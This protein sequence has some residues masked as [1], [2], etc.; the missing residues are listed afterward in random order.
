MSAILLKQQYALLKGSRQAL[1]TYCETIA[2]DDLIRGIEGFGFSSITNLLCHVANSYT[3][4]LPNFALKQCQPYIDDS[5]I[6]IMADA[7][8]VYRQTDLFVEEFLNNFADSLECDINHKLP[9]R[10][11]LLI[12]TPLDLFTHVL[13]HESHHKGQIISMS[14]HLGYLPIDTDVIRF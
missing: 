7:Y 1:F 13:T 2:P 12:T 5:A 6:R 4:W 3:H 10:D 14:R 8:P 9:T 11:R